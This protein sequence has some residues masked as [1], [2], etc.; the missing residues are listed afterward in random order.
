[1]VNLPYETHRFKNV[2]MEEYDV[3]GLLYLYL[4]CGMLD[5][6]A[7]LNL[8]LRKVMLTHVGLQD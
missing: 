6:F 4:S 1:M 8:V 3:D 7:D 5:G 2:K